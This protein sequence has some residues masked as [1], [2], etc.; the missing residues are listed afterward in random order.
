MN[1]R[2][3]LE[4]QRINDSVPKELRDRLFKRV[5][6]APDLRLTVREAVKAMREEAEEMEEGVQRRK[7]MKEAERLQNMIDAG[8]YDT[9]ELRVDPEV[10][11]EMDAWVEKELDKAI[12][13]GRIPHPKHDRQYQSFIRKLKQHEKRRQQAGG[14][15]EPAVGGDGA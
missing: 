1:K 4:I 3:R 14:D 2:T 13:E 6:V 8:Y 15:Q 9:T 12:A 10:A 7:L 5:Y 11:K